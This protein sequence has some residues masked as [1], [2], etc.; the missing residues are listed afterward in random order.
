[1]R[2]PKD[3]LV[4]NYG[5]ELSPAGKWSVYSRY[6][7]VVNFISEDCL[8]SI[9][10]S[11]I[12][13]GVGNLRLNCSKVDWLESFRI[14]AEQVFLNG[15]CLPLR[16][17]Q[18]WRVPQ[19]VLP[20][21]YPDYTTLSDILAELAPPLSLPGLLVSETPAGSY[22]RE[23]LRQ[24]REG[25]R[26][27]AGED[28]RQAAGYLKGRG[29]GSTPSGT[30]LLTGYLLA[31]AW[32]EQRQKNKLSEIADLILVEILGSDALSNAFARRARALKPDSDWA[33]LLLKM[34]SPKPDVRPAFVTVISHGATSGADALLGFLT[35]LRQHSPRRI[36]DS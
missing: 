34:A 8:I 35:A 26:L 20:Q 33:D 17:N 5:E 10:A 12:P 9:C 31:L 24:I 30:D 15:A 27:L 22:E 2:I 28:Y 25:L 6:E 36:Y 16:E 21:G 29:Y 13:S 32:L 18:R 4:L 14:E 3:L 23:L 11:S 19:L 1:M 7:R